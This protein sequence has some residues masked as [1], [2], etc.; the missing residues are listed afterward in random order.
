[1]PDM[2]F[3]LGEALG[4]YEQAQAD[5][6]FYLSMVQGGTQAASPI[7]AYLAGV[8]GVKMANM[9]QKAQAVEDARQAKLDATAAADKAQKRRDTLQSQLLTIVKG[10]NDGTIPASV[11]ATMVGPIGKELGINVK[12]FDAEN[13]T[14][15]YN[16]GN[17]PTDYEWDWRESE[18]S[19]Q[20]R[21]AE[22]VRIKWY[23]AETKR[24]AAEARA[25]A[26][27][28]RAEKAKA[29]A[30]AH[31]TGDSSLNIPRSLKEFIDSNKEVYNALVNPQATSEYSMLTDIERAAKLVEEY[32]SSARNWIKT[33]QDQPKRIQDDL[34]EFT[35]LLNNALGSSAR[36]EANISGQAVMTAAPQESPSFSAVDILKARWNKNK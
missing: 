20:S 33:I 34:A 4:G 35:A 36:Q 31:L 1:M 7:A 18:N 17:D 12:Q 25:E 16:E 21:Q 9:R 28:A 5:R 2:E 27:K 24:K 3:D 11:G 30:Q 19:K 22:A 14:L 8:S 23:E 26:D 10:V 32:P 13:G 29:E 6:N 15:V